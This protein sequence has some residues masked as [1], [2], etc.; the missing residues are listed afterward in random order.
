MSSRNKTLRKQQAQLNELRGLAERIAFAEHIGVYGDFIP[1]FESPDDVGE[2]LQLP[3]DPERRESL[4]F[5]FLERAAQISWSLRV[6]LLRG[7]RIDTLKEFFAAGHEVISAAELEARV[8]SLKHEDNFHPDKLAEL[9]PFQGHE[10]SLQ[11]EKHFQDLQ[12]ELLH[13]MSK[14]YDLFE[15]IYEEESNENTEAQSWKI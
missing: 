13:R 2:L 12:E 4:Y 8:P 3:E 5:E 10:I 15:R 1:K 14:V 11:Q 7:K 9:E 6:Y